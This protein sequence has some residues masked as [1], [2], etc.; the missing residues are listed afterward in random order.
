[1]KRLNF[2]FILL[3]NVPLFVQTQNIPSDSLD[4]YTIDELHEKYLTYAEVDDMKAKT[5]IHAF[6]NRVKKKTNYKDIVIGY[7][8]LALT[9]RNKN[10]K[11][12]IQYLDS[13]I[14]ASRKLSTRSD[15]PTLLSIAKGSFLEKTG[16]IETALDIYFDA[17]K[18][19][20]KVNSLDYFYYASHNIALIKKKLQLYD[21]VKIILKKCLVHEEKKEPMTNTDSLIYLTNLSSLISTYRLNKQ[22]D[23]TTFYI[24]KGLLWSKNK[25]IEPLFTIHNGIQLFY[26]KNYTRAK[27]TI[28]SGISKLLSSE[29]N[30]F[31]KKDD[32]ISAYT[33]LGKV[34]QYLSNPKEAVKN[35]L[36]VDS[37]IKLSADFDPQARIAYLNLIDYYKDIGNS[38]MRLETTTKL[39]HVDSIINA[40]Y[41]F[42]SKKITK[43]FDTPNL[44]ADK[45][46]IIDTLNSEKLK[47]K[48][49]ILVLSSL[50]LITFAFLIHNYRKQNLYKKRFQILMDKQNSSLTDTRETL[51]IKNKT[52]LVKNNKTDINI[53]SNVIESITKHL[54]DFETNKGFLKK[55]ITTTILA[56]KFHTNTK[57]LSKVIRVQK[58]KNFVNYINDLRIDYFLQKVQ[59]DNKF[60]QYT[61]K[62]M[63]QEC[64]FNTTEAFS[65]TF[66]KKT[67]IYPS[68]YVKRVSKEFKL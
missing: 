4:S 35:Y 54:E 14:I 34:N 38:N 32:F 3:F 43:D 47:N 64:G 7:H 60:R 40:N 58:Q 28:E 67:G 6:L 62:A 20:K 2:L 66:Y 53:A 13:A 52:S 46:Q 41:R 61:I 39:L 18:S 55:Q 10:L 30:F 29:E 23:S 22:Y 36:K 48:H 25:Y 8:G 50:L 26:E 31:Y 17:I 37:I 45:E 5:Y 59:S 65:K 24:Q 21:E 57:Y 12:G 15:Y 19:A 63:S 44:I 11:L 33:Y 9:Y 49:W 51:N 1:L 16:Q 27:T 42:I 56:S 68:Y